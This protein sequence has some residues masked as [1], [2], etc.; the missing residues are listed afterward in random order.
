MPQLVFQAIVPVHSMEGSLR[1]LA[2][3][4]TSCTVAG[5]P[6]AEVDACPGLE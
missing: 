3:K 6:F 4:A 2:I 5:L 1:E